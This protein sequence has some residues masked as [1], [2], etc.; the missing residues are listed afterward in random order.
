[1]YAAF[2]KGAINDYHI[3]LIPK[4]HVESFDKLNGDEKSECEHAVS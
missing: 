4:N 1:M 2:P 3:L